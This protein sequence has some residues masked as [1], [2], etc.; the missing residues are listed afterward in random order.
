MLRVLVHG[1]LVEEGFAVFNRA[2]HVSTSKLDHTQPP[3]MGGSSQM[4]VVIGGGSGIGAAAAEEL[5][6]D[7]LVADRIG[8]DIACDLG[9]IA[10][11]IE[12]ARQVDRLDALVV[13][14]GVSPA[15][16]DAH[17]I[18][19]IDL[20]GMARVLQAFDRL[21]EPG[22][23]A[24]CVASMAGH[25]GSWPPETLAAID[26]PLTSPDANLT[27]DSATAYVLAKM[28]VVRLVRREASRWGSRGGRIVSVSPGV[29]DTPMGALELSHTAGT[30]EIVAASALSRAGRPEEVASVIAFLCSEGARYVTGVDVLVDGGAVAALS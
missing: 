13:T 5:P 11:L 24:V 19:D 9:D 3:S 25:L 17:T 4:N 27:D 29:I 18:F 1:V 6:G 26:E 10:S 12:V 21:V 16:A 30:A 8:G 28:G 23:V 2:H 20:A 15:M 14:A 7:T 22:S